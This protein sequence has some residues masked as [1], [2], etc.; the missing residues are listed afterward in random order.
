MQPLDAKAAHP[1]WRARL[2]APEEIDDRRDPRALAKTN[3]IPFSGRS[4]FHRTAAPPRKILHAL[5]PLQTG[6][7]Q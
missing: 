3:A 2:F 4:N 7:E 5:P 6:P 1:F